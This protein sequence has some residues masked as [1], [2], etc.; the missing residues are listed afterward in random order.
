MGTLAHGAVAQRT[1]HRRQGRLPHRGNV[2][3]PQTYAII[4][5]WPLTR[6]EH[7]VVQRVPGALQDQETVGTLQR[8][9]LERAGAGSL[10]RQRQQQEHAVGWK[11]CWYY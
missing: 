1:D 4:Q 8:G 5:P 2:E 7:D 3:A 10:R 11:S 9:S 6:A